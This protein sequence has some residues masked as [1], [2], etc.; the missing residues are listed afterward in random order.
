MLKSKIQ[1]SNYSVWPIATDAGN[2]MNQNMS[3]KLIHA[4]GLGKKKRTK[5]LDSLLIGWATHRL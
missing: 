1:Y 4:G 2:Q 5:K 3:S